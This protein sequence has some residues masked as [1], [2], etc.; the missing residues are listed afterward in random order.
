[1]QIGF[2]AHNELEIQGYMQ[3]RKEGKFSADEIR[4]SYI[5]ASVD[6]EDLK[7]DK[8]ASVLFNEFMKPEVEKSQ[9]DKKF[10]VFT[11]DEQ[12]PEYLNKQAKKASRARAKEHVVDSNVRCACCQAVDWVWAKTKKSWTAP[13]QKKAAAQ[14]RKEESSA[15]RKQQ[16][17]TQKAKRAI[18]KKQRTP[19][20]EVF[21]G[22]KYKPVALKVRPV[23]TEVPERFRIKRE[24]IGDPLAE[25]P[26]LPTNPSDFVPTG[27]YT[28]ERKEIIDKIHEKPFLQPEEKKLMHNFMMLQNEAF[29]WDDSE[30]GSFR[31][32][33]FP[34]IEIPVVEHK[35]WVERSIPIPRG[36]LDMVCK[37]IKSK[38]SAGVY[39]PSNSSYRTKFFGVVKKDGQSIRLVHALEP[40][41][42][43]TIAHSGVPPATEELANHFA[44]RACGGVLDLYSGYDHRDIAENSRDYTT[45]Q[46]PFGALRLVKL[47]QGWTNSVPIFHDDVTHILRDEIPHV[48][49]PYIDDVPI[50]GPGTRYQN[51][52][53]ICEAI[54]E[55]PGIRRFVWEH[56]QNLNRI[57][58]RVKYCR[59]TF[60]GPKALLCLDEFSVVG[61]VCSFEGRRPSEDRIGVIT[62]WPA[63]ENVSEVRQF[64][65]V[66]GQV[67]MF[68]KN[69]GIISRPIARLL[70][71]DIE[72]EW[73]PKQQKSMNEIKAEVAECRALKP[74]NYEWDSDIVLAVDT[75]WRSV[76]LEVYQCDPL[77]PTKKYF[78]KFMAIPLNDRESRFSQPK[79]ELYGLLRALERM[80]Y[81]LL[82]ARKLVV[83]TDALYI[84]GMLSNPGMGPNAT[85]N[86]WIEQILMFHFTLK[87]VAGKTFPPDGLSR[88]VP[89]EGDEETEN[90]EDGYD[91][92]PPPEDH[93]DWDTEGRQPLDFDEFKRDIDTRGGYVQ[94][95]VDP[96]DWQDSFDRGHDN[97]SP[98]DHYD[99]DTAGRQPLDYWEF[100]HEIDVKEEVETQV[101]NTPAWAGDF[102][103][104]CMTAFLSEAQIS[105]S[106]R[107]VYLAEGKEVPQYLMSHE[108]PEE[109][110]LPEL[111]YKLDPNHRDPYPEEH[112]TKTARDLDE[113]V[114]LVKEWLG[115]TSTRPSEMS[116]TE[117]RKF[118]RYASLFFLDHE[119]NKLYRR[120]D[121]GAHK[122]VVDKEHRMYMM[123][124]SHDSLGHKGAYST[125]SMIELRFWW[126]DY[127][128][129]VDWY[130]RSC[131]L[132]QVRQKTLLRIPPKPTM[133][134]SVFQKI[135]TDVMIMGVP[136]NG[137]KF[138]IAA[139]DS[140]TR[141][142][143]GRALRA[144]NGETIG[145]FLL[146][147]IICRWGCPAEI[148]TDNAPQ[149]IAALKWLSAKYGIVGIQISAYNSQANGPVETGHWDLRQSLYKATGGDARKW[150]W[151]LPQTLWADRITTRRGLGCTPYFAMCGAHPVIPLDVE[152]ATWL[153]EYP[154]HQIDTADL[155]GLRARALAKHSYHVGEM[156]ERVSAEKLAAARRYERVHEHTIRDFD[157][158]PGDFVLVRHTSVE[159]SLNTKM[160]IR[161][162]GPMIV[163][164][165]TKGG[166]YLCCE[167]NGA[168]LHGK[169][170]QFRVIP[171]LA[172]E[173]MTVPENVLRMIDLSKETLEE[174]A[175]AEDG[176]DEYLGKDMQ[177]HKIRIR[178]DWR[179]APAEDLSDDYM[180]DEE[181]EE[182]IEPDEVYDDKNPRR[183]KR[184]KRSGNPERR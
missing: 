57:A 9:E 59:G 163:V 146:E 117:Y 123:R 81:W 35:V 39:E 67:R 119:T 69:Y 135:H 32:D 52:K 92:N 108:K 162:N 165:R 152:E 1:M 147:E 16:S 157:F 7:N 97:P 118:V 177:F 151:F 4:A 183:S 134:P 120:D 156:R 102:E 56:F 44:G 38:I 143:E 53:G 99:S 168:M 43:V 68:I 79:R 50:R 142:L 31:H 114:R 27:R 36:Q 20:K 121:G 148:V 94:D 26:S 180:S 82:G 19:V 46:T 55:N 22:K 184:D 23:F 160:A 80:K 78:A 40:L 8:N 125:K 145:K 34:P 10:Q 100:H 154:G 88:R 132:C 18:R 127:S 76:G 29:A 5:A 74:L 45:F 170:A 115:N 65:G 83:E 139:R 24:I 77:D 37:L 174:L 30:R 91:E 64:L 128:R 116:E 155:V 171:Y 3:P 103:Q 172:R 129:D 124:A 164:R 95:L 101:L 61:H 158:Q 136:S 182:A 96:D 140:L 6:N 2:N 72:F 66:V 178:P 141:Y 131:H 167:M 54:P 175:S 176:K 133:T 179:Q 112:R 144:D 14:E 12:V 71:G 21:A 169:I 137:C 63:L 104:E 181:M 149:F 49:I 25:M 58:Q 60:S 33:F 150:Y 47:P 173:R 75:S 15:L 109:P 11:W 84:K 51:K 42:A 17:D 166:S 111:K 159:K 126:P 70:R 73:G 93:P 41:N 85:I 113:R 90:I 28:A 86:R 48:T 98:E 110:L 153:V 89:Q 106:V 105:E 62:R 122:L 161:Y 107:N 130:V 13:Y 138:V 87:H